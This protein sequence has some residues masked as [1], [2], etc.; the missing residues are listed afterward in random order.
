MSKLNI[1]LSFLML[2]MLKLIVDHGCDYITFNEQYRLAAP[3]LLLI[4]L[5]ISWAIVRLLFEEFKKRFVIFLIIAMFF[6]NIFFFIG[7][8]TAA[9]L[10]KFDKIENSRLKKLFDR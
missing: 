2:L 9:L 6:S 3:V 5:L 4:N 7:L 1:H 8:F 10:V